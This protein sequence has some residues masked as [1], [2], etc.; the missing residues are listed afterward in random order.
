MPIAQDVHEPALLGYHLL[1]PLPI[2]ASGYGLA[3]G[4]QLIHP[5]LNM[6]SSQTLL[7]NSNVLT[8]C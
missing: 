8:Q 2:M 1:L 5:S 3:G 4:K 6:S 7:G